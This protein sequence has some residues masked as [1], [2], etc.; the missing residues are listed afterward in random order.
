[1]NIQQATH[2]YVSAFVDE[3]ARCGVHNAVICPG[4]RSTP[5][6]M[7]LAAHAE[8][9]VWMH[10][11]ERSAAFFALGFAKAHRKPAILVCTSGTAAAN[12]LPAVV[13]AHYSHVP[14]I[15]LTADRPPELR[16]VGAPQTI[17]QLRLYGVHAKYFV[18]MALPDSTAEALRYVRAVAVRAFSES[19]AAPAGAVHL[20]FPFR[21]PL[22][23]LPPDQPVID[24]AR[25]DHQPYTAMI[26]GAVR[27]DST[28]I[29]SLAAELV[30]MERGL[31]VCGPQTD[32]DFPVAV[33]H[34]AE[35]LGW[36]IL[37]DPLS[38]VRCGLHDRSAVID[39]YDAFLRDSAFAGQTVPEVILRFGQVP[40]SKPLT[41]YMQKHASARQILVDANGDW[42]DPSL[43][44]SDVIQADPRWLC[45][46]LNGTLHSPASARGW[47]LQWVEANQRTRAAIADKTA[48]YTELFEGSV[49]SELSDLLPDGAMLYASSSMPVRDLDTFFPGNDRAIRF[50]ANR[51][52]NGID[53][54]ISSALGA[55][56]ASTGPLV[57]VIG[58]IAFY[59]DMNG[60]LAA[61][62]HDLNM[63]IILINNDGG[64]IFSFLPQADYP[65][66]FE[67]LF[68]TPH[69]LH[70]RYA[71][72]I[73][74]AAYTIIHDWQHFRSAVARG[75]ESGGLN[76][77]E[78]R[79][80]R[81]RNVQQHR[82]V[83][84]AVGQA[85]AS[86]VVEQPGGVS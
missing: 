4:S 57:L 76:I 62:L 11:D 80:N 42:N 50:L 65:E 7:V 63:T 1:M 12:F 78:L 28:S 46:D 36:P 30:A 39:A 75:L 85:V 18:E 41:Q 56:A 27:L 67:Q 5:L 34:L 24:A 8:I 14:L 60:L 35:H 84:Q 55:S 25:A 44:A 47:L 16:D 37:A 79:T 43:L 77:V 59:H 73:Y 58:D 64:G 40:T 21:E 6:A 72:E 19:M 3:L 51:G 70:F 17:D 13:E 48:S 20:N 49:F 86:A 82:A 83:W 32:P 31:I 53:G 10:L 81:E 2:A 61:K 54:V 69:G 22:V 29:K 68:G 71:A 66:H 52:A 74:G 9:K 45:E 26:G 33:S 15:V 38:Q 23:P